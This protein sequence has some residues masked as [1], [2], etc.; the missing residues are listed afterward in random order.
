MPSV[1]SIIL[2][3]VLAADV[4]WWWRADRRARR[5][6]RALGW[7][8]V[9]GLFVG[10]Q[11]ALVLW[12]LSGR[13]PAASSLGRPPQPLSAAAYLWHLLLLPAGWLLVAA[14][15]MLFGAW[16]WGRRLAGWIAPRRGAAGTEAGGTPALPGET[17]SRRRFLGMVTT[18]TPVLLTGAGVAYSRRQVREF[19]VRPIGVGLPGLP[20]ELDGLRIALVADLHVGTFTTG[21][22]VKRVVEETSRLDADLVL[23]PGDLINSA[24]ADLSDA[25]DAVANMQS[26]AGAYLCVGNHDLIEDGAEFVRRVRAR[27][28]LLVNESRVVAVRGRPVQLLG[29]PWSSDETRIAT[30]VRQL[31]G[32][33]VP[34]AFPILL[35]HHPHAFDAAAAAGIPLTVSGHTHGGQLMLGEAVG[36]GPLLYRYWSG[37]YRKPGGESLVV[38]NG[39][40]N[41]FPLRVGALAEIIDLTLRSVARTAR[42]HGSSHPTG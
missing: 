23:L 25:L 32:Q 12:S 10:G 6:P 24:L 22:T 33:V 37:L 11:I 1:V 4:L 2:A 15:G 31:A 13:V 7:R 30:S 40:G 17:A 5:W 20:P 29:L 41:W 14:A 35:A 34:G 16:R 3:S 8:L 27:A 18:A 42:G 21:Q 26:R 36:F 38:S 9:I 39:V 19:R 28:P